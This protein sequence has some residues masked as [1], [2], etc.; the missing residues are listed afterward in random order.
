VLPAPAILLLPGAELQALK[1][2]RDANPIAAVQ[3]YFFINTSKDIVD[4][5][6]PGLYT[7][8]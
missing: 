8:S 3:M 7:I 1:A 2:L 6:P 5:L 4:T